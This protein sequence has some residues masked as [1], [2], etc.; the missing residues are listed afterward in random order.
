MRDLSEVLRFAEEKLFLTYL[1]SAAGMTHSGNLG[2]TREIALRRVL[3]TWLPERFAVARGEVID[4]VGVRSGQ[5]DVIIFDRLK[6]APLLRTDDGL[7]VLPA[8]AVLAVVEVKSR[9]GDLQVTQTAEGIAKM[10]N[11]RAFGMPWGLSR[12]DGN[13]ANDGLPNLFTSLFSFDTTVQAAHWS[14]TEINRVRRLFG[15]AE[16]P[17]QWLDR[18]VV[19]G[20]GILLPADGR[21]AGFDE[22]SRVMGLWLY[23]L[24]NFLNREADRRDVFP[25][26]WYERSLGAHWQ[27]IAEPISDAEPPAKP[28]KSAL[29]DWKKQIRNL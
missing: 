22:G 1:E 28:T 5:I 19:L 29:R 15:R 7:V 18:L 13:P 17:V 6:S 27:Q 8:E 25:W 26:S 24:V 20:R 2:D 3:T 12:R 4:A 16:V 9:L 23:H 10:R 11:L 14:E 21:A